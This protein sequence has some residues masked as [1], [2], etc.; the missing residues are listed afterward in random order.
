MPTSEPGPHH[1]EAGAYSTFARNEEEARDG[2]SLREA[3]VRLL[4]L[5]WQDND[6]DEVEVMWRQLA[7]SPGPFTTDALDVLDAVLADPPKDLSELI[8]SQGWVPQVRDGA[9][10]RTRPRTQTEAVRWLAESRD[11][12][13]AIHEQV[14][15]GAGGVQ[16]GTQ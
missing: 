13:L 9:D 14:H 5:V 16:P 3:F 1:H 6:P 15:P 10:G 2:I 12:L 4:V 8:S 7:E 11:R